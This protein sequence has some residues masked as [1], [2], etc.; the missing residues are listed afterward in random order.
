V[1]LGVAGIAKGFSKLTYVVYL[2]QV[3][4][5]WKELPSEDVQAWTLLTAE[6]QSAIDPPS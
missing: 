1:A 5:K 3:Y 2:S 4:A 6:T